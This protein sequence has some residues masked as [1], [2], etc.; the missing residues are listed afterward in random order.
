MPYSAIYQRGFEKQ[1]GNRTEFSFDVEPSTEI[2]EP[3]F[4]R[5]GEKGFVKESAGLLGGMFL[6]IAKTWE[7]GV[8]KATEPTNL[9]SDKFL[10]DVGDLP[11][12]YPV[13][14]LYG[15]ERQPLKD[16][17]RRLNVPLKVENLAKDRDVQGAALISG[18]GLVGAVPYVGGALMVGFT[19]YGAKK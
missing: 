14:T 9:F 11:L 18:I 15:V 12:A 5:K 7:L 3:H 16:T 10:K 19:G 6:D 13:K 17:A 8:A 4:K 1:L 2:T